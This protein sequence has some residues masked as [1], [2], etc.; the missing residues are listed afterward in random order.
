MTT[1]LRKPR[2]ILFCLLATVVFGLLVFRLV[3]IQLVYGDNYSEIALR[4]ST[5]R[6]E[7][8]A[9][10]GVIYDR[11][12]RELAINV[13]KYSLFAHAENTTEIN[14]IHTYLDSLLGKPRSHSRRTYSLEPKKFAWLERRFPDSLAKQVEKDT[15]RGLYIDPCIGRSYPYLGVGKQLLGWTNIDGKGVAGMEFSFD[16]LL[17]GRPGYSE[18][19]RDGQRNTYRLRHLS[20]IPPVPGKSITLTVDW[21]L[22]EIVED[23][24]KKGVEKYQA[25][26]G[27]ALFIDCHTGEILAA[28]DFVASGKN[29]AVKLRAISNRFEPG[30]VFKVFTAAALLDENLVD[31]SERINCENGVWKV[32]GRLLRDD[33]KHGLLNLREIIER[34][35]NIGTAKLAL[36]LGADRLYETARRFGFGQRYYVGL[37]GEEAGVINHPQ[38]AP[39]QKIETSKK[40]KPK[41]AEYN[42]AALSIGH[43]IS[44]TAL[45]LANAVAAIANGGTLYRPKIIKAITTHDGKILEQAEIEKIATVMKA[46]SAEILRSYMK[47]VVDTGTARPVK[48]EI[49]TIAGKTG[50]AEVVD[51]ISGGYK[52][53]KFVASFLGFFPYESPRVAG[54]VILHEPEPIHYGGYTAGPIFKQIAERY[55]NTRIEQFKPDNKIIAAPSAPE[56]QSIPDFVGHEVTQALS[57]ARKRGLE[58]VMNATRGV[59]TWQFPPAGRKIAGGGKVAVGVECHDADS[60]VMADLTGLNLRTAV[61]FLDFLGYEYDIEGDGMVVRHEPPPGEILSD[62]TR[63]LLICGKGI[64]DADSTEKS[65]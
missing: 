24:L 40:K 8:P 9:P 28:A 43:S 57:L 33:K 62:S 50:T 56:F 26:E 36:R 39:G 59:I 63:F 2:L 7:I 19:L 25:L 31:L 34:S 30:S 35:S 58:L 41:P 49:V 10:R 21:N 52:K 42:I 15:V 27:N 55:S 18:Y 13:Q 61:S 54:V 11:F 48:S 4:Q 37:P 12:G 22:Q 44:V 6:R 3:K 60:L 47:G 65:N 20:Q 46:S 14:R 32:N 45:Q 38:R 53:N 1:E 51:T 23:E 17:A 29:D 16:T 64:M 5:G